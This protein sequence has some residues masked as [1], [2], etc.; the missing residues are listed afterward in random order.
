VS[1]PTRG[2]VR[3]EP[4]ESCVS[5]DPAALPFRPLVRQRAAR[6][7][8][9]CFGYGLK[10]GFRGRA[11]VLGDEADHNKQSGP[12]SLRCMQS[13]L[14]SPSECHLSFSDEGS[15]VSSVPGDQPLLWLC[16]F[17]CNARGGD[18]F[19]PTGPAT[20]GSVNPEE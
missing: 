5:R 18:T 16:F 15:S 7:S 6:P 10:S 9:P 19:H 4:A 8:S 3:R 13:A 20:S 11:P 1:V 14:A 17:L 12:L 2:P